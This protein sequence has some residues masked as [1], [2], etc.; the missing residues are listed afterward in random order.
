MKKTKR[1]NSLFQIGN[2][3][4]F[5]TVNPC[6]KFLRP[7]TEHK[8]TTRIIW[9]PLSYKCSFSPLPSK[10][11]PSR[12][13]AFN[14]TLFALQSFGILSF[15]QFCSLSKSLLK[16]LILKE[17]FEAKNNKIVKQR[18]ICNLSTNTKYIENYYSYY[19]L[20]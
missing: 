1:V 5:Q 10:R 2:K 4:S 9:Y 16:T 12:C 7:H 20:S 11:M 15:L 17:L 6:I 18:S 8:N 3:P 19:Q 13:Y 14:A